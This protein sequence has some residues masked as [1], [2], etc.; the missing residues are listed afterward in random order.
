MVQFCGSG[1]C[2]ESK[3]MY[4]G[5]LLIAGWLKISVHSEKNVLYTEL[6]LCLG[7]GPMILNTTF[8]D[9]QHLVGN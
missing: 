7:I 5:L 3:L 8:C 1:E 6:H 2:V 4:A 9:C